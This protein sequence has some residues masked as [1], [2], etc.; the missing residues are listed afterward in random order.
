[1]CTVYTR[2]W[3]SVQYL[4][5]HITQLRNFGMSVNIAWFPDYGHIVAGIFDILEVTK[6]YIDAFGSNKDF[7]QGEL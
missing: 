7:R 2:L 4:C 6:Q 3:A 1:M 5:T